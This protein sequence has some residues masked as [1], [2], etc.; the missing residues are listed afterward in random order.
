MSLKIVF[1][2][3]PEFS[4]PTLKFLIQNKFNILSVYTQP[5]KKSKRGQKINPSPVEK[6][7]LNNKLNLR[8]PENLNT[9]NELKYFQEL[10]PD[11]A[12]VVAYGQIIPKVFLSTTRFGFINIHASLLPKW[13]GAAP[14]QRAIMN[15]DKKTGVSIMKIEE[16]LDSGPILVSKELKLN[17][18]ET[19][20]EIEKKISEIGA[21]LLIESLKNIKDDNLKF[22]DQ[23]HSKATYAKKIGKSETKINWNLDANKVLAH[24]HGLSPNPGAWFKYENERFKVLK[25]KISTEN[26]KSSSVINE[27]LTVACK[28]NSI[29]IL[30]LQRQGKNKQTAKDFLLG[31]KISN[32]SILN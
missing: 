12:I 30:E 31:K 25:A 9:N 16:K 19:H 8:N 2:G 23:V 24:I 21:K 17:Q 15:E 22:I 26:G 27:N 18:N 3:T 20:G 14:I 7:S 32:G 13:R 1:M 29:K 28:T 10:S 11:I 5:P 4:V 6:F